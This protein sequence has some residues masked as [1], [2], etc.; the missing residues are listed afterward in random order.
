[1]VDLVFTTHHCWRATVVEALESLV[2]PICDEQRGQKKEEHA[3]TI[4]GMP[5][6]CGEVSEVKIEAVPDLH[7]MHGG[8]D[9]DTIDTIEEIE[10]KIATPLLY[11]SARMVARLRELPSQANKERPEKHSYALF[12]AEEVRDGVVLRAVHANSKSFEHLD[13]KDELYRVAGH[14]MPISMLVSAERYRSSALSGLSDLLGRREG[15][16][17]VV[18]N[19]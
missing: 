1:M 18:M 2:K 17:C 6:L 11:G 14:A 9:I 3:E 13:P 16:S 15:L 5:A 19:V 8:V 4:E 12:R 7:T 10:T